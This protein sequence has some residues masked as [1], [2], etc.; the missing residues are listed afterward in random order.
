MR[1]P[2]QN[3]KGCSRTIH[4]PENLYNTN[5]ASVQS[6]GR[7]TNAHYKMTVDILKCALL[8]RLQQAMR[9]ILHKSFDRILYLALDWALNWNSR[10]SATLSA[11]LPT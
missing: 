5:N 2:V 9:V 11:E 3:S 6:T 7:T 1:M 4:M 10:L 8:A